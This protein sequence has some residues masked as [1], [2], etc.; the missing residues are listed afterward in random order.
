MAHVGVSIE[1][2]VA[3]RDS[4]QT[5]ANVYY[6]NWTGLNP[7][8]SLATDLINRIVT[9]EKAIHS[10]LVTFNKGR[11]W[12]A[13]GSESA[14]QM[15]A[16]VTLSGSGSGTTTASFDKERAWLVQW[17]GGIDSRGNPVKF[18]KWFHTCGAFASNAAPASVL[19]NDTALSST[20]RG[21]VATLSNPFNPITFNSGLTTARLCNKN[22]TREAGTTAVAH[23]YLEHRQLGDQWR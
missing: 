20:I 14:N 23:K 15:I 4:A 22:N 2:Q 10:S 7:G 1:K 13:G 6:Y 17:D 9:L 16:E 3:F 18:R 12:S 8:E 11:C 21:N 5:F 19:T